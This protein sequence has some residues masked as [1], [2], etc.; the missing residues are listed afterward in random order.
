[1]S[2]FERFVAVIATMGLLTWCLWS[3]YRIHGLETRMNLQEA[4]QHW[5]EMPPR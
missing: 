2:T 4:S 3:E 1:M 5:Q